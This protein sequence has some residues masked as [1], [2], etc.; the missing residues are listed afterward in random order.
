MSLEQNRGY[1]SITNIPRL[2]LAEPL[3][4]PFGR[5]QAI[6]EACR[7]LRTADRVEVY[8]IVEEPVSIGVLRRRTQFMRQEG[9]L[10]PCQQDT[11]YM[12][13]PQNLQSTSTSESTSELIPSTSQQL[14]DEMEVVPHGQIT[15]NHLGIAGAF[16]DQFSGFSPNHVVQTC[17]AP[18]CIAK[19][20]GYRHGFLPL[21]ACGVGG[22]DTEH[23]RIHCSFCNKFTYHYLCRYYEFMACIVMTD[24]IGQ[25]TYVEQMLRGTEHNVSATPWSLHTICSSLRFCGTFW[26][27]PRFRY[28]YR[29]LKVRAFLGS[30]GVRLEDIRSIEFVEYSFFSIVSWAWSPTLILWGSTINSWQSPVN[31]YTRYQPPDLHALFH[32]S[33]V[34]S[35]SWP[36]STVMSTSMPWLSGFGQGC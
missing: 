10:F 34:T 17:Q 21:F 27:G 28:V 26:Y 18:W 19:S 2:N 16:H 15:S 22:D 33:K 8:E 20:T 11:V 4:Q 32:T 36:K 25:S 29:K 31:V 9:Y 1:L 3:P 7:Q 5:L 30:C 6:W 24:P 13:R 23:S 35:G 12:E 14:S